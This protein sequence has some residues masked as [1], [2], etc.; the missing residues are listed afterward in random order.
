MKMAIALEQKQNRAHSKARREKH[1]LVYK[2][3]F[4]RSANV[5]KKRKKNT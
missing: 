2:N 5:R 3:A 1:K 4:H